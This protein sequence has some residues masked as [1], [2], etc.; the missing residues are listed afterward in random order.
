MKIDQP[1]RRVKRTQRLLAEAL[2]SLTLDK[3]YDAVTIRDITEAA[4]IG[5]ATF[6][7]HYPDKDALL[8]EVLRVVLEQLLALLQPQQG[9]A[10]P[11]T[12]GG[13]LFGY[14]GEHSAVCRVLLSSH[15]SSDLLQQVIDTGTANVLRDNAPLP[16]S[17]VPMEIAAHHIVASSLALIDWWL[18]HGMP[19]PAEAMGRIYADMIVAPTARLAFAAPGGLSAPATPAD[20]R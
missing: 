20:S 5:Y 17:P 11:A 10:D 6:F 4:D 16:G 7:R 3:G 13:L 8:T 1:D 2:I 18:D 15:G 9:S 14:V 12:I 19:Y